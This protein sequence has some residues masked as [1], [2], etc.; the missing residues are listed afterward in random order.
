MKISLIFYFILEF[1][2]IS[3]SFL[4]KLLCMLQVNNAGVNYNLGS[5]NSVEFA[6]QVIETNYYGTKNMIKAMIPFMRPSAAGARIVN[7]SSKL[8]KLNGRRNVSK[9]FSSFYPLTSCC[10]NF[11]SEEEQISSSV[12]L[13]L[14]PV[15]IV[16]FCLFLFLSEGQGKT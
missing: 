2:W 14:S 16:W 1:R 4:I 9:P 15:P 5:D 13:A 12:I 6:R 3:F 11:S 8:G 7:V 10:Y